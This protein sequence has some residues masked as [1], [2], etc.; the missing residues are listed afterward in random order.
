MD[1]FNPFYF[2]LTPADAITHTQ[3]TSKSSSSGR[4][5]SIKNCERKESTLVAA[6]LFSRWMCPLLCTNQ[7]TIGCREFSQLLSILTVL[8]LVQWTLK[9]KGFHFFAHRVWTE[10]SWLSRVL[11]LDESVARV[12]FLRSCVNIGGMEEMKKVWNHYQLSGHIYI[13]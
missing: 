7:Q 11:E 2:T 5:T 4:N 8:P 12:D 6:A 10:P 9:I 13:G 3:H 1:T